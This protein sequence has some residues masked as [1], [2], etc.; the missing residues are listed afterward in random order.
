MSGFD[1]RNQ[2][3][4]DGAEMPDAPA[5][6]VPDISEAGFVQ[7]KSHTGRNSLIILMGFALIGAGVIYFLKT[8][9]GPAQ[10][11]ASKEAGTAKTTINEFLKGGEKNISKMRELIT[12]TQQVVDQ[13]KNHE[14]LAQVKVEDL[15]T[16]PFLYAQPKPETYDPEA[17]KKKR[18]EEERKRQEEQAKKLD[19]EKRLAVE[20]AG[21]LRISSIMLAG[22]GSS[23]IIGGKL[24]T[25]GQEVDGFVIEQIRQDAVRVRRYS[26]VLPNKSYGFEVR[27]NK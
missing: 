22:S 4:S 12:N 2:T 11:Q 8:K 19:A 3:P 10:A 24:Y 20:D 6:A 14:A 16:N 13:F 1:P 18:E 9:M 25:Q 7:E 23:V 26:A 15:Q 21:R 17:E 5:E 27:I